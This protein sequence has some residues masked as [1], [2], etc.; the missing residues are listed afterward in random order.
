M[1][2]I[3][4]VGLAWAL[5]GLIIVFFTGRENN[6]GLIMVTAGMILIAIWSVTTIILEEISL[7]K[8]FMGM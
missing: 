4:I 8:D 7:I 3:I 6:R 2:G 5:V 1:T